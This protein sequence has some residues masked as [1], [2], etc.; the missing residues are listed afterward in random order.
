[1]PAPVEAISQ[2]VVW[3][4]PEVKRFA[5][6][7][8]AAALERQE[9]EGFTTDLVEDAARGDGPGIAGTVISILKDAHVIQPMGITNNGV[10]FPL[11]RASERPA[12]RSRWLNVYKLASPEIA[13]AFLRANP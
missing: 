6:A 8:V 10:F 9:E 7:L 12:S 2:Q 3:K 4:H 5:R 13:R 1:M 11:R